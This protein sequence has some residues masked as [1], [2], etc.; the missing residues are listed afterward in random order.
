MPYTV[1][2]NQRRFSYTWLAEAPVQRISMVVQQP[3]AATEMLIDPEPV[4]VSEGQNDGLTY[5]TLGAE[6]APAGQ[7]VT[8]QVTYTMAEERLTA[9]SAA[10]NPAAAPPPPAEIESEGSG[11]S[12][13]SEGG[14]NWPLI[15]GAIGVLLIVIAGTWQL[16]SRSNP[17]RNRKPKPRRAR[18]RPSS[19]TKRSQQRKAN[20]C[21]QCGE[22][23]T[24]G[25]KFCRNC[26]ARIKE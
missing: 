23:V 24:L 15:L 26:G 1:E 19:P 22:P 16:A 21:H 5:Y 12:L 14:L 2:G 8:V 6:T 3:A 25:D 10:V 18:S 9:A 4:N 11:L 7:P 20:F 17:S 13:L